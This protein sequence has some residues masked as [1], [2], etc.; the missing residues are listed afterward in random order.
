MEDVVKVGIFQKSME[1]DT[2][3]GKIM[4]VSSEENV[5]EVYNWVES[6]TFVYD[7]IIQFLKYNIEGDFLFPENPLEEVDVPV[8]IF[9]ENET[10]S[11]IRRNNN[12][13]NQTN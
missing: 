12:D 8:F 13:T 6:E 3:L 5:Q 10:V 1:D 7:N 2:W 4:E 9:S 11:M